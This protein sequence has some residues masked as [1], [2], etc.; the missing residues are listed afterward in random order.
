MIKKEKYVISF[1]LTTLVFVIG[2]SIG[3][4]ITRSRV[5]SIQHSLA[6][7][8]LDS[9]SLEVELSILQQL[10][11]KDDL[12]TYVESRLPDIVRKKVEI[13]RR[14]DVG[15]VPKE[16]A[17]L[18]TAQFVVSLGR[19][20]VFEG[21]QEKEC[22]IEKPK[23]LFFPDSSET[24]REQARVL[25]NIVFRL[26]DVNITVFSFS[27]VLMEDQQIVKLV[28]NLNNVTK[29]PTII[30]KGVK[31]ESFQSL[32]KVIEILCNSYNNRYTKAICK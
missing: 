32:D 17:D 2:I 11:K 7:D 30:I 18:L 1:L 12:C 25:D 15:D 31:Y 26:G 21:I 23:V 20:I 10:G 13:G 24:S 28:Y 29:N 22:N 5:E 9:Q 6:L 3:S 8:V 27:K 4:E 16:N 19:Y 14:F